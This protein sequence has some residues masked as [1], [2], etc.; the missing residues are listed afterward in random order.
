[1][2]SPLQRVL[3]RIFQETTVQ[4][5]DSDGPGSVSDWD[6]HTHLELLSQL[7]ESYGITLSMD[8]QLSLDTLGAIKAALRQRGLEV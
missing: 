1:M 3:E 5:R 2:S 4:L 6:S 7:E 8:E